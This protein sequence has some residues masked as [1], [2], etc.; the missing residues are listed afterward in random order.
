MTIQT[1]FVIRVIQDQGISDHY[2]GETEKTAGSTGKPIKVDFYRSKFFKSEAESFAWLGQHGEQIDEA[3]EVIAVHLTPI[4]VRKN[5]VGTP[6]FEQAQANA[7]R[8]PIQL[9]Q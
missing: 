8:K 5:T 1:I 2:Y 6:E 3:V 9:R 4:W 7:R